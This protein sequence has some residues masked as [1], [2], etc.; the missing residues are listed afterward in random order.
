[1]R[2]VT[3]SKQAVKR[4]DTE[5]DIRK[6]HDRVGQYLKRYLNDFVFDEFSDAFLEK[7]GVKE[8]MKG[9]PIPLRKADVEQ[10]NGGQGLKTSH[11]A[12]NMAWIM[13]IDPKFKYTEH[14]IAFLLKL[15]NHKIFEGMLKEGRDAA[16]KEEFD[17]ACIHFRAC[18][19][20]KSDYLD[21]MYSYARVCRE[22]YLKGGNEDYVG[23]FK[24]ESIDYFEL[25]TEEY[26]DFAQAYYYLGYAYL[27]LGLYAKADI[28]W[29]QF[30]ERSKNSQDKREIKERL[31]QLEGPVKIEAGCN[32]VMAGRYEDGINKLDSYLNSQFKTWWPLPY[33]LGVAY[34]RVGELNE[35][36]SCFKMVL[37]LNPSHIETMEELADIYSAQGDGENQQKYSKKIELIKSQILQNK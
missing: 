20:M 29:R 6:R 32:A 34:S 31:Q 16:E 2:K 8:L 33:Y 28:T 25:L 11:I 22:M 30:A 3:E 12:E 7:S 23:N 1:M 9:V 19:C 10:F 36:V 26:P 37:T 24:A 13:G 18:L 5:T 35:A 15:Y 21:G 14:Y 4:A 17:N 27:N